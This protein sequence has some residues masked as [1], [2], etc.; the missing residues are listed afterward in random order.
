ML[1]VKIWLNLT[2]CRGTIINSR[3]MQCVNFKLK[4]LLLEYEIIERSAY[5]I[6]SSG[7]SERMQWEQKG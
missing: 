7:G 4:F 1:R 5:H 2:P 3:V 6:M